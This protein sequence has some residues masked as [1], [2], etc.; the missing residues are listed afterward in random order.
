MAKNH[1]V[2]QGDC[3]S[4]IALKY[5]FFEDTL[6]YLSDNFELKNRRKNQ[7]AL[8]PGDRVYIPDLRK[9]EE[10]AATDQKTRFVRK[11]VPA[12]FK[13]KFEFNGEPRADQAVKVEVDA[14]FV[15]DFVTDGDG[16][17]EVPISPT[18][19][20]VIVTYKAD[21]ANPE[22]YVFDLGFIDPIDTVTGQ[23]ARLA[24]LGFYS[25]DIDNVIDEDFE[26]NLRGFQSFYDIEESG[27]ADGSTLTKLEE[28]YG[29]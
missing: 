1:R 22:K 7:N 28:A 4:S 19:D 11:G 29:S 13:V 12:M 27:V 16:Q 20:T 10:S 8:F 21:T 15:G 6:W 23:K 2:A 5:G 25:G 3:I 17:L 9:K 18:A 24:N 26:Q 14:L